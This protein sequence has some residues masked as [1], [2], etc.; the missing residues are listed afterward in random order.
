MSYL[1]TKP[2]DYSIDPDKPYCLI[3]AGKRLGV[4]DDTVRRLIDN[5]EIPAFKV[6]SSFRIY[7]RDLKSYIENNRI[8]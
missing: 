3:E 2:V 1:L 6:R 8:K 5:K 7:G 4:S